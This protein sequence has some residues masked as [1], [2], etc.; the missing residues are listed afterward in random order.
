MTALAYVP[1]LLF[2]VPCS[3][4][5]P[6]THYPPSFP[7]TPIHAAQAPTLPYPVHAAVV[8]ESSVDCPPPS[9]DQ[10]LHIDVFSIVLWPVFKILNMSSTVPPEGPGSQGADPDKPK[11]D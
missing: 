2:Q 6:P 11:Q 1:A 8:I 9:P 4:P 5:I 7:Y 10:F 3:I